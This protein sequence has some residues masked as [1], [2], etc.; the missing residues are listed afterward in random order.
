MNFAIKVARREIGRNMVRKLTKSA[1]KVAKFEF[2]KKGW[3]RR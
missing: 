3:N 1:A 2:F